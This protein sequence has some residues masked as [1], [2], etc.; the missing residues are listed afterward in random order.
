MRKRIQGSRD[1][2]RERWASPA[3]GKDIFVALVAL[4]LGTGGLLA[5]FGWYVDSQFDAERRDRF[6]DRAED[7]D[8]VE[9]IDRRVGRLE[10]AC[11]TDRSCARRLRLERRRQASRSPG[12]RRRRDQHQPERLGDPRGDRPPRTPATPPPAPDPVA[13]PPPPTGA[14]P[15][16]TSPTAPTPVDPI[17]PA[18]QVPRVVDIPPVDLDGPEGLVPDVVNVPTVDVPPITLPRITP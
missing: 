10:V 7:R 1:T 2:V 4:A 15:T 9:S 12:D 5:G 11:R 14:P 8:R 13:G 3:T 6:A 17:D 16:P 18:P